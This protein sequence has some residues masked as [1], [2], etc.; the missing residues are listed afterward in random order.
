MG[1]CRLF[2]KI[3]GLFLHNFVVLSVY[4]KIIQGR[5]ILNL[6]LGRSNFAKI[7]IL[8]KIPILRKIFC[9]GEKQMLNFLKIAAN[10]RRIVVHS[11]KAG[12][13]RSL[14]K[15]RNAD[16]KV[17]SIYGTYEIPLYC[18]TNPKVILSVSIC[19]VSTIVYTHKIS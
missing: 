7:V 10:S 18:L 4:F 15:N 12:A 11:S 14:I 2:Y 13:H 1:S 6:F 5:L 16:H 17:R 9:P 8:V 3:P 19:R